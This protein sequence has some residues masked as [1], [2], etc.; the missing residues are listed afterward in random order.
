MI[1]LTISVEHPFMKKDIR[2]NEN[3]RIIDTFQI[4][5]EKGIIPDLRNLNEHVVKSE[6]KQ[7]YCNVRLTYE[8]LG[9]YDGDILHLTYGKEKV[10]DG[11]H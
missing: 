3:Q 8:Q 7:Q 9:I 1:M 11:N 6:R 2:I 4:L 5:A 10:Q